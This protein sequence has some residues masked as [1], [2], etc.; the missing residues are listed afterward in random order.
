M[1]AQREEQLGAAPRS[2]WGEAEAL[3]FSLWCPRF[4]LSPSRGP[5]PGSASDGES[6]SP[7]WGGPAWKGLPGSPDSWDLPSSL[8]QV[9]L[10]E[11]P[12]PAYLVSY[13]WE[14]RAPGPRIIL[15]LLPY[16]GEAT[17]SREKPPSSFCKL[18]PYLF[19][20]SCLRRS[21]CSYPGLLGH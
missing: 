11:R 3:C 6:A 7:L 8:P 16:S 12:S 14:T 10:S 4:H 18:L 1:G 15:P 17:V 2:P 20:H 21:H 5:Q 9:L 19:F 13:L